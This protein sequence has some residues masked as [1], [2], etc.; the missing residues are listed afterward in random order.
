MGL[1]C[2]QSI[3]L[4]D[5]TLRS[6]S[7]GHN[8]LEDAT[9]PTSTQKDAS[10]HSSHPRDDRRTSAAAGRRL[11]RR[12]VA[13]GVAGNRLEWV[14]RGS[15]A[16]ARH[17]PPPPSAPSADPPQ[18]PRPSPSRYRHRRP[19]PPPPTAPP[20]SGGGEEPAE[21]VPQLVQE[22][23]ERLA[24]GT[25]ECMICYDMVRRSAPIWS[26]GSCFSIFH[27]HCIRKWARSPTSADAPAPDSGGGSGWR[28]PGCQSVQSVPAKDLSYTCFCARRR[29]PPT[30]S[31]SLP[32][33]AA[34]P[35]VSRSIGARPWLLQRKRCARARTSASS[36]AT[37]AVP[38]VQGVRPSP[39]V[40]LRQA[41]HHAAVRG[42]EDPADLR[43][44]VQPPA[45]VRPPPVRQNV[46]YGRVR[47]LPGRHRRL[48]LLQEEDRGGSLRRHG[49]EG[50][51]R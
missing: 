9:A 5:R 32:T 50:R 22:I 34:S 38:A 49:R 15:A 45:L 35:A 8:R 43:A 25:V 29:D 16:P 31:T 18:H 27:L 17:P 20:D 41:D 12:T 44:A 1:R 26:C 11:P 14:P 24:R 37:R 33:P 42:P 7:D 40:P 3:V 48:L 4:E 47:P 10:L 36:N 2:D 28:C 39:V 30:T 13:D 23:Q 51:T 6:R 21:G 46:P 19:A